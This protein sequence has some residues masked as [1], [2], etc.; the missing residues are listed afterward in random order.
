V[1]HSDYGAGTNSVNFPISAPSA[2]GTYHVYFI[3][4]SDDL[5]TTQS[6]GSAPS[7]T[8]TMSNAVTVSAPKTNQTITFNALANKAYGDAAFT[9]VATSS[10]GLPVSFTATGSCTMSGS[11]P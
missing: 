7:V 9:V 6:G 1:N 11:S 5:C 4:Y 8:Y 10:S 3:A 2:S